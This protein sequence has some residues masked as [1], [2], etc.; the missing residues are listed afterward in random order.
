MNLF[1][2]KTLTILHCLEPATRDYQNMKMA[3]LQVED[4]RHQ[5]QR[6]FLQDKE[7]VEQFAPRLSSY[8]EQWMEKDETSQNFQGFQDMVLRTQ[9]Q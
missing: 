4:A 5:F 9:F 1:D 6:A 2:G 8:L 3:L 7:I